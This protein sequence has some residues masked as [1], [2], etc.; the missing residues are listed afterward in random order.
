MTRK[1]AN[2]PA[3][4]RDVVVVRIE[5]ICVKGTNT[6]IGASRKYLSDSSGTMK[7]ICCRVAVCLYASSSLTLCSSVI[8]FLIVLSLNVFSP[9]S[10]CVSG[11]EA[12]GGISGGAPLVSSK[13][14]AG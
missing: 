6:C 14:P 7:Q 3:V 10:V 2:V 13:G 11:G 8:F 5:C 9:T 1:I 12:V 4:Q